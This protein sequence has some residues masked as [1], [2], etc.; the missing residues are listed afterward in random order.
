MMIDDYVGRYF[1]PYPLGV[2]DHTATSHI[3][4]TGAT[5]PSNFSRSKLKPK[6]VPAE[7]PQSRSQTTSS[8]A[9]T[10]VVASEESE[11]KTLWVCDRCFK[12]MKEG[13][14]WELHLVRMDVLVMIWV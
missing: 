12:Y 6:D 4:I 11:E 7:R 3:R 9:P 10:G 5:L 8:E 2:D 13:A 1:S 14:S